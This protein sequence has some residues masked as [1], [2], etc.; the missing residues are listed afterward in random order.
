LQKPGSR[1][2]YKSF[3]LEAADYWAGM[4]SEETHEE[5]DVEAADD[6]DD[7]C[8]PST[9]HA[10][11]RDPFGRLSRDMKEHQ[12]QAIVGVGK[13]KYPQKPCRVCAAHRKCKDMRYICS[14][15]KVPLRKGDCFRRCHT[16]MKC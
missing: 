3:L 1:L 13:K 14:T 15:F 2:K 16:R 5:D 6:D 9:P 10:P 7:D 8:S 12:F 11:R 4:T